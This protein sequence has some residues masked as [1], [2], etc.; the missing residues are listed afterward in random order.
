MRSLGFRLLAPVVGVAMLLMAGA[1]RANEAPV[2]SKVGKQ[3]ADFSLK[4]TSGKPWSLYGL[5]NGKAVVVVFLSFDCPVSISYS[6]RLADL[7]R[8]YGERGV[9]FVGVCPC[10]EEA[11][12]VARHA[13]DFKLPFPVLKDRQLAAADALGA[14]L[15]PEAFLLDERFV[16]RYR[17]R[18]DDSY[19]A[20]LKKR[21][22]TGREDLKE[23]LDE[24]LAGKP[25]R[26]SATAPIGCAIVRETA[27]KPA[28][29][30]VT[31]HRDVLP[32]LQNH[33]QSCHRPGEV[34]PFALTTYKQAVNWAADIKGY[35]HNHKMPPWKP[36]AGPAFRDERRLNEHEI[37]TLAAWV[38]GGT[39]AG[40]PHDA[41]SPRE[42]PRGWQLGQPDLVLTPNNDFQLGASGRDLFRCFVLP[43]DLPED[44][45]V[46]AV[47]VR[48]GNPSI[49]HHALVFTDSS[50][51]AR[52]LE[53]AGQQREKPDPDGD[54]GPGYTVSMGIGF[55][56]S[57]GLGGWAPGQ[58][59]RQLPP[60]TFFLIPKKSDVVIQVHYHRDGRVEKDQIRIG[61]YFA[62][63]PMAKRMQGL[64]IPGRFWFI[65][66]GAQDFEVKGSIWV[67]QDITIHSVMPHMHLLGKNIE[68]TMTPPEGPPQFLVA[69]KGWDYNWQETYLF[70][71][72]IQVKAGTRF[73]IKAHYDNSD[74]NPL[75]PNHPPRAVRFGEQTTDEMCFGFIGAT[76]EQRGRI[77]P[78]Y[79]KPKD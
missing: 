6:P 28:G 20:R 53:E 35:T 44:K 64:A 62:K 33:C 41:P 3:V 8:Q 55:L 45:Q 76:T 74:A 38:D 32:I 4:D 12:Q 31:Y 61:L 15:T 17:G 75:N 47:E 58:L 66:A 36:V 52:K 63:E 7:A 24:V 72:P 68:V 10:D 57:G 48:P 2:T 16:L 46:V 14:Q 18:I 67:D 26:V 51:R 29:T 21:A 22:E 70:R 39:P 5:K 13:R 1:G 37:A 42:F 11:E 40:D 69:I 54:G 65:P 73:D 30:T 78:R 19:A 49:V 79:Q 34:A 25:V 27:A 71:E 56:P 60:D 9:A 23:A 43:V 77:R 50:G 59:A